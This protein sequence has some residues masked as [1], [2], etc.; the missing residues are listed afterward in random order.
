MTWRKLTDLT[1]DEVRELL[2]AILNVEKNDTNNIKRDM[3]R[4]LIKADITTEWGGGEN[5]P[6]IQ[7]TDEIEMYID[8]FRVDFGTNREDRL[9]YVQ[10]LLAHNICWL[11]FDNPYIKQEG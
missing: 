10:W 1:D 9:R 8:D 2:L 6:P 4:Q 3:E 11:A 7:I 5:E